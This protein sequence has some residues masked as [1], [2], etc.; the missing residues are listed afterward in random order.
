MIECGHRARFVL[1]SAD[2]GGVSLARYTSPMP[3][4]PSEQSTT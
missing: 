1:E 4:A 3:P 2:A